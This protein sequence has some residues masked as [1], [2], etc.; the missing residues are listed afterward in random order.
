[1]ISCC[2]A[3]L[4]VRRHRLQMDLAAAFVAGALLATAETAESCAQVVAQVVAAC[5]HHYAG[6]GDVAVDSVDGVDAA[7]V[8]A[9]GGDAGVGAGAAVVG[10]EVGSDAPVAA[11]VKDEQP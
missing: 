8:G 5:A 7:V 9:G 11:V 3:R 2:K 4:S 6:A 1:M 10:H